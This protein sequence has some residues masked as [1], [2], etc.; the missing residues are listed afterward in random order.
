[1]RASALRRRREDATKAELAK[2]GPITPAFATAVLASVLHENCVV[3][4]E[5]SAPRGE[6]AFTEPRSTFYLPATGGLGWALPAAIGAKQ[7]APERTMIATVGDGTYLFSNPAACHHASE[8]HGLPVLTVVL[9]NARWGAVD[10]TAKLVYPKGALTKLE[11]IELSDL[12]PSPAFERAIEASNGLGLRV[13]RREDLAAA[14]ERA[15]RAVEVEKR[16]ALVNVI[17]A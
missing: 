13:E 11:R 4:N 1:V 3:F 14:Y 8:K 12:S 15:L 16:Q 10:W 6:L 2:V 5:Y 17:C 9:N 7:I